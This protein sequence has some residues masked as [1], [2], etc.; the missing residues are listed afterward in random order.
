MQTQLQA[1]YDVHRTTRNSQQREKLLSAD[2]AGVTPD[3]I[4]AKLHDP[5]IEPGFE[6][7]RHCLVFWARPPEAVRTLIAEIQRRLREVV[8]SV[9]PPHFQQEAVLT[10]EQIF[11]SC[12]SHAST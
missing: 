5:T 9:H 12:H 6:D 8:P 10:A 3:E 11:G 4:L 1:R 7:W 2:F